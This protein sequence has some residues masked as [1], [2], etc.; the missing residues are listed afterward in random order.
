MENTSED[1]PG[2]VVNRTKVYPS[3]SYAPWYKVPGTPFV[4]VEHPYIIKNVEKGLE[5]LGGPNKLREVRRLLNFESCS[6][7]CCLVG[8]RERSH[9]C[10]FVSATRRSD[11]ET[12]P[13]YECC[14]E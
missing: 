2:L 8:S 5:L 13:I 11:V 6:P 12:D 9:H 4:S 10:K 1:G 3:A 14:H 7:N